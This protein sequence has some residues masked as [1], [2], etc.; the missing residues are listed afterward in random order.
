[1]RYLLNLV[2][3]IVKVIKTRKATYIV[4]MTKND[5]VV[6]KQIKAVSSEKACM[7]AELDV[8]LF[9]YDV[10]GVRKLISWGIIPSLFSNTSS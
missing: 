3:K 9:N 4:S 10:T 8:N 7:I 6:E 5:D 2:K 1:M